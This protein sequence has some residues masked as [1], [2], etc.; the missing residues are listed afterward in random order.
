MMFGVSKIQLIAL[1]AALILVGVQTVRLSVS[2]RMVG[3]RDTQ[4]ARIERDMANS[5]RERAEQVRRIEHDY[6][7][8]VRRV[9]AHAQEQISAANA[10]TRDAR[11]AADSLRDEVARLNSRPAPADPASAGYA[12]EAA[13]A[14]ELLG[15][16]VAEYQGV[17]ADADG[18]R[19]Q[20]EGLQGYAAAV[21]RSAP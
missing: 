5:A 18:L 10:R 4:I 2:Q 7:D 21:S 19:V 3:Q 14:R 15:A 9:D 20:V 11:R 6:A 12:H 8:A 17:A 16:C 1:A 13:V